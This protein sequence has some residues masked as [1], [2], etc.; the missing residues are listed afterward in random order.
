VEGNKE[1]ARG[2]EEGVEIAG[3]KK[4]R[5]T[6]GGRK[7]KKRNQSERKVDSDHEKKGEQG[8]PCYRG[9][10]CVRRLTKKK[11]TKK[12]GKHLQ[13]PSAR[14]RQGGGKSKARKN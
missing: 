14:G 6:V 12:G 5:Q 8:W 9:G 13:S 7:K 11:K 4:I 2:K 3:G 10:G 1:G